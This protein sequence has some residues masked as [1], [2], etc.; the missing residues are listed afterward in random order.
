MTLETK[1][2]VD[3][4]RLRWK[5]ALDA[6]PAGL[7]RIL[8]ASDIGGERVEIRRD[9]FERKERM[10][11]GRRPQ[12]AADPAREQGGQPQAVAGDNRAR[13]VGLE[14]DEAR[15]ALAQ[16]LNTVRRA[17]VDEAQATVCRLDKRAVA[18][19]DERRDG[20]IFAVVFLRLAGTPAEARRHFGDTLPGSSVAA[21]AAHEAAAHYAAA[22]GRGA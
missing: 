22:A 6:A 15:S 19:V 10:H 12:R 3:G 18:P 1:S 14:G 4:N 5:D 21:D 16:A 17:P 11:L 8:D 2:V 7:F 20:D 13:R 9:R